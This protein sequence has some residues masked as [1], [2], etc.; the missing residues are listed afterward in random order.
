MQKAPSYEPYDGQ[1]L[2]SDMHSIGNR[3]LKQIQNIAILFGLCLLCIDA[4]S[5]GMRKDLGGHSQHVSEAKIGLSIHLGD[6]QCTPSQQHSL[7]E[8]II[9]MCGEQPT[10]H[11]RACR[12]RISVCTWT[13]VWT[14]RGLVA[15]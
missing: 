9:C 12:L 5:E 7:R 13:F 1:G 2:L 11:F 10:K 15:L 3:L 8:L 4:R 14:M 6:W